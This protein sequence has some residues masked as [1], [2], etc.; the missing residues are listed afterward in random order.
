MLEKTAMD[1]L[2]AFFERL[3]A[4]YR[5]FL[6]L[7]SEKYADVKAGRLDRLDRRIRGEQAYLLKA[8]GLERERLSLQEKAGCPGATFREL[9]PLFAPER[10]ET[11]RKL[12][13]DLS[14]VIRELKRTNEDCNRLTDAKLRKA[15]KIVES[16]RNDPG[17]AAAYDAKV[18]KAK[19]AAGLFSK[20]V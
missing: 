20:K 18:K 13:A 5:S 17:L 9:I 6:Q 4:F 10:Q 7:E 15:E 11:A 19:R 2:T 3:L 14:S 12:Y 16:L 1:D 8:R